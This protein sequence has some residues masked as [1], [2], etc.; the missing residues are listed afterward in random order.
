MKPTQLITCCLVLATSVLSAEEPKSEVLKKVFATA[1]SGKPAA[2]HKARTTAKPGETITLKG[3]V[4]GNLKPFVDGRSIFIL[5]DPE[6]LKACSD[7]PGDACETPWD[8]CCDDPEALKQG[9]ATIQVIDAKGRVLKEGIENV[10]GLQKLSYVTVSG[11]VAPG[12]SDKLLLL[13]ADAIQVE[14][15]KKK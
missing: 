9:T 3:R 10:N 4:M 13:N 11:T 15:P 5:G 1:P 6:T 12:S 14:E 2:I 7:I 8:N